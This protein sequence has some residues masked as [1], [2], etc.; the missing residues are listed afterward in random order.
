MCYYTG[1][2]MTASG[3]ASCAWPGSW[4]ETEQQMERNS[5]SSYYANTEP[6]LAGKEPTDTSKVFMVKTRNREEGVKRLLTLLGPLAYEGKTIL[7]KPNFNTADPAPGSTHNDTLRQLLIE[8]KAAG[9]SSIAVG[10][11]SG[12]PLTE[13]VLKQKGVIELWEQLGITLINYDKL[14]PDGWVKFWREGLHWKD[15]FYVAKPVLDADVNIGT[16]TLKTHAYGGVFS[17]SLKLAVGITPRRGY[18]LMS[19]LHSSPHMGK[20]IAEIN[21]AYTPDFVLM[22]GV[23]V[24]VDGGP[25]RGTSREAN[26]MLLSRDRIALDAVGLA[27]LK[28]LGSNREIMEVP[29]FKQEQ[30]SRAVELG[31]GVRNADQIEIIT[32]D[33]ESKQYA[34]RLEKI[35]RE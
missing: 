29:I 13:N 30:I 20:M 4:T 28:D 27:I 14:S 19:E 7:V 34:S 12:P 31:L 6:G 8:L 21:L 9:P 33:K 18:S 5:E 3:L 16:C 11:R 32:D 2:G 1:L 26:V 23:D 22:D 35:L 10:E 15:G 25:D 24:F 17:M